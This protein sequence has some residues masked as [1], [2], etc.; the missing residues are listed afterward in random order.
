M[1]Y[2]RLELVDQPGVYIKHNGIDA[3]VLLESSTADATCFRPL[4]YI[5]IFSTLDNTQYVYQDL[6]NKQIYLGK[7]T[8]A[9][10]HP[11]YFQTIF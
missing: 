1:G 7:L 4:H 3:Q 9:D 10:Y 11:K 8:W 6:D 2:F 5:S